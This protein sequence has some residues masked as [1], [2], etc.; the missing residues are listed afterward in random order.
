MK[1]LI[2]SH[3]D[4]ANQTEA[5]AVQD[6][7]N[8]IRSHLN[9]EISFLTEFMGEKRIYRYVDSEIENNPIQAGIIESLDATYYQLIANGEVPE[10]IN[11]ARN[12]N[13]ISIPEST[14]IHIG[15]YIN[16]PLYLSDGSLFGTFCC[17]SRQSDPSLNQRDLA[18][19]HAF[20]EL[21]CK[22]I[23]RI[24]R[25]KSIKQITLDVVN[26]IIR[27]ES[28]YIAYQPIFDLLPKKISGFEALSRF[29]DLPVNAP[30]IWFREAH[31]IG[32]GIHLEI[33]AIELA[34]HSLQFFHDDAYVSMNI[35]PQTITS[36]SLAQLFNEH[37]DLSRIAL[38]ITEHDA[39]NQYEEIAD[40]L[41][42][43]RARGLKI[44]VDDAGSG[45]ASFRHILNLRPDYIKLD[46][47]LTRGIDKDPAKRALAVALVHFSR[48]TG[49]QLI[50]EGVETSEELAI[51]IELGIQK[52]QGFFL[53]RP[54][55]LAELPEHALKSQPV[56]VI[57]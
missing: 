32:M 23:E 55:R 48:D 44:A 28:M 3:T 33:R 49:S 15:S 20:A 39:V 17:L 24:R 18:L 52:A 51:L 41:K 11:D 42:P 34:M 35:S 53:G 22:A 56:T 46:M 27:G 43:Y 6:I 19:T 37:I 26:K 29:P 8:A 16:V 21:A 47:S 57:E 36:A 54:L 5:S 12:S 7:L 10:L 4:F 25:I 14:K 9:M 30:D 13:D 45:Y 38:E 40:R 1:R 50:A 2:L 31:A